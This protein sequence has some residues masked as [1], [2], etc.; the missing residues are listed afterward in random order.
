MVHHFLEGT[1]ITKEEAEAEI[2]ALVRW[3][4]LH[5][6]RKDI[7]A[8]QLATIARD[9][10]G[11]RA[12]VDDDTSADHLRSLLAAG[13]PIIVPM[14]GRQLGNPYFTGAGPWYHMLVARGYGTGW[15]RGRFFITNDPGTRR[16]EK[17]TYDEAIFR[18]AIHDWVGVNE[19]IAEGGKRV[20]IVEKE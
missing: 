20:V 10:Y 1:G 16:G 4:E 11:Y 9:Y 8:E 12:Y 15:F 5:G 19:R 13:K 2:Q 14:A 3:E 6:Y 18:N 17:Y 7:T